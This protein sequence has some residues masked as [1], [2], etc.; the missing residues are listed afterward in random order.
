VKVL[1]ILF[2][3][4]WETKG[5][6]IVSVKLSLISE[7]CNCRHTRPLHVKFIS[8]IGEVVLTTDSVTNLSLT[9]THDVRQFSENLRTGQRLHHN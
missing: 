2:Y 5:K 1:K 6:I 7:L 3:Y 4:I 8:H 9:L